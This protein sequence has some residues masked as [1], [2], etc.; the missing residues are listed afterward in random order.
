MT[1]R[2]YV[3]CWKNR[4]MNFLIHPLVFIRIYTKIK[5]HNQEGYKQKSAYLPL[6][7]IIF[8][9]HVIKDCFAT[10]F[11]G[12]KKQ[13]LDNNNILSISCNNKKLLMCC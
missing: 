5:K 13:V 9:A 7:T 3:L 1:I 2:F 6:K 8:N 4:S 11:D 12:Q 10:F